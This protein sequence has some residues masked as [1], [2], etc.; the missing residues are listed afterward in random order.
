MIRAALFLIFASTELFAYRL[1]LEPVVRTS[2]GAVKLSEVARLEGEGPGDRVLLASVREPYYLSREDIS[3]A[4]GAECETIYGPGV[5]VVPLTKN[6]SS[7]ET[8]ESLKSAIRRLSGGD[9]FLTH[10]N[11]RVS[12]GLKLP[13]QG[14]EVVYRLPPQ[15]SRLAAG[16]LV[17]AV[18]LVVP[19]NGKDRTLLRQQIEVTIL[20]LAK[21]PV[22]ARRLD[23]GEKIARGDYRI[24]TKELDSDVEKF[25]PENLLGS[26]LIDSVEEGKPIY[27]SHLR[28]TTTVRRGQS[29]TL[30]HQ[31]GGIVVRCKSTSLTDAEP[32]GRIKV[33][34]LL[35][36]GKKS[37]IKEADVVD[38]T[39]A[40]LVP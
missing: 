39:T 33:R 13:E 26:R 24:E 17:I 12:G 25:A 6:L 29:I 19:E 9:E 36:S 3:R 38:E 34:I 1:Y 10:H 40:V 8:Q 7:E 31:T 20:R 37:D 16:K 15:A 35:P 18:D 28:K 30:V 21:V 22:A 14:T 23:A 32:G 5:W 4:L 2:G 11:L 27:A